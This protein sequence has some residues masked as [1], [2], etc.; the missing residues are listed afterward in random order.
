MLLVVA[1][2]SLGVLGYVFRTH[3]RDEREALAR[4]DERL[5]LAARSLKY[6]LPPDYHDRARDARSISLEEEMRV[7]DVLNRFAREGGFAYVYTLVEKEGKF[8]FPATSVTDEE[9]KERLSW[10][11]YPYPEVP[12]EFVEAHRSRRAAFATYEDHWGTF[13]SALIPQVSPGGVP[14]LACAD[15]RIDRVLAELRARTLESLLTPPYFLLLS[16]P[17]LFLFRGFIRVLRERGEA[18]EEGGERLALALDAGGLVLWDVDRRAGRSSSANDRYARIFG[19]SLADLPAPA[20]HPFEAWAE[21]VHPEDRERVRLAWRD[22]LEGR[23]DSF[24]AE[25]RKRAADGRFL[26]VHDRGRVVER[27]PGGEPLRIVGVLQDIS[28]RKGQEEALRKSERRVRTILD[29]VQTGI[30]LVDART[31]EIAD[32]NPVAARLCGGDPS[33]VRGRLCHELLCPNERGDCPILDRGQGVENAERTLLAADGRRV[34]ILKTVSRID[35]G[36]REY[37]LESFVDLT[38]RK[39]LEADLR[40]AKEAAEEASR[41][42]SAFV[43]RMSHEIRTPLHAI[44]GYAG[45][46]REGENL[47]AEQREGLDVI[48]R[49]G[50]HLLALLED[51]LHFSRAES[52]P[53]APET[54]EF[55]PVALI[56]EVLR[57]FRLRAGGKGLRLEE[58]L[59]GIPRCLRTDAGKVRQVL[60]NL[61]GNA[62]RYT[63][64]G[65]VTLRARM[66]E[67]NAPEG[68]A[69]GAILR[70]EVEDTGCGIAPEEAERIFLPFER[71]GRIRDGGTGLGLAI[72]RQFARRMGGDLR[73]LRSAPDEGSLFEFRLPVTPCAS[74]DGASEVPSP[75]GT[76]AA[77][78][79][80][81]AVR[82]LEALSREERRRMWEDLEAGDW[83]GL[84]VRIDEA[85]E[86]APELGAFLRTLAERYDY[87]LMARLL[88]PE[89]EEA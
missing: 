11:F 53:S 14:Y 21:T 76:G 73:L 9:A 25:Y 74:G 83:G 35:L 59:E 52:E 32:L 45:L 87:A 56:R 20:D 37:L 54:E 31:R 16:L 23:S 28:E 7:R 13:R 46:L 77:P 6:L 19:Y 39:A 85:A 12:R 42:K 82:G 1:V 30:L 65:T 64:Q 61:V 89:E 68:E 40:R 78:G 57:M 71:G 86:R 70:I 51:I 66:E 8:Y 50:V 88:A 22:H 62:I 79:D 17:A 58:E 27:D 44:L 33:R 63:R 24:E 80:E 4:I 48:E 60:I 36:G 47:T 81:G 72:G 38:E 10:Y 55:D 29:S 84:R 67:G 34:P 2:Y 5:E 69:G 75:E 26:W 49:G 18:L 43:A 15:E 3:Q 41:S